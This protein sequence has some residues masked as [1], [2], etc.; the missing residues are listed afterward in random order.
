MA[1]L[2]LG[3]H[4]LYPYLESKPEKRLDMLTQII[5]RSAIPFSLV[6]INVLTN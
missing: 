6:A 2:N 3:I 1:A 4:R 5:Y